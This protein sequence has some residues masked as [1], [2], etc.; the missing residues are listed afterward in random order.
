MKATDYKSSA[1]R[2]IIVYGGPKT[3]KT[4][5]VGTLAEKYRLWWLN[6][7]G[8]I[9]TLFRP[10]SYAH[11]YLEN[12]ELFNIPDR[13]TFPIAIETVLKVLKGG[14]LRICHKHGKVACPECKTKAPEAFSTINVDAF[15]VK[16]DVLVIDHYTQLMDSVINLIH[17]D[18]LMKDDFDNIKSSYD[19]WAKQGAMSD[20][21]GS[22]IQNAPYN[23]VVISHEVLTEL[24]D[25]TK[26]IAP[27]GGTRNKSAD[28]ARYFDDVVYTEIVA[29]QY[30]AQVSAGDKSRTIIGTRSGKKLNSPAGGQVKLWELF[31]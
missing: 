7:D 29:G 12:I 16:R 17:K 1:A 4:E 8:G 5:L 20:R 25:G 24:E 14:E 28:F 27:V 11:K 31:E 6:L 13:Q 19:D 21:I 30:K 23:V 10:D 15:D 22:T 2:H 9:K 18:A 26:K 3:G